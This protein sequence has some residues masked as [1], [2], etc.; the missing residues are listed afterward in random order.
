MI[1]QEGSRNAQAELSPSRVV[2]VGCVYFGPLRTLHRNCNNAAY[3]LGR[4]LCCS[5]FATLLTFSPQKIDKVHYICPLSRGRRNSLMR[6]SSGVFR[7]SLAKG[8]F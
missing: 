4:L 2:F 5:R 6:P 3:R 8:N 1:L 7:N